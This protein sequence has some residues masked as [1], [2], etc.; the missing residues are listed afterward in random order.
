[1]VD[2]GLG[3]GV[4]GEVQRAGST[5]TRG[6]AG[7]G[8]GHGRGRALRR[9]D[10]L[11]VGVQGGGEVCLEPGVGVQ[12]VDDVTGGPVRVDSAHRHRHLDAAL[13]DDEVAGDRGRGQGTGP[14]VATRRQGVAD[15][16]DVRRA[17]VDGDAAVAVT[18]RTD[19]EVEDAGTVEQGGAV[20]V[21]RVGDAA[22]LLGELRC[23]SGD[24]A[25]RLGVVRVV[26]RLD[27]QVTQTLQDRV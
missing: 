22:E 3:V 16:R 5:R 26:R 10:E 12:G 18:V 25:P 13:G 17:E 8:D 4:V 9:H 20:E 6:V 2:R 1:R 24:I 21:H 19:L 14:G 11:A 27:A 23:L 15:G 7:T